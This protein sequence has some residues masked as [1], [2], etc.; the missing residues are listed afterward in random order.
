MK[1]TFIFLVL[2]FDLLSAS[3]FGNLGRKRTSDT[4]DDLPDKKKAKYEEESASQEE[5]SPEFASPAKARLSLYRKWLILNLH[6]SDGQMATERL[7][8]IY[9]QPEAIERG[10]FLPR[11][12]ATLEKIRPGTGCEFMLS[13][14]GIQCEQL[15]RTD[16]EV[17]FQVIANDLNE[18]NDTSMNL[19]HRVLLFMHHFILHTGSWWNG[20]VIE[21]PHARRDLNA[22]AEYLNVAADYYN[23][24]KIKNLDKAIAFT[25][26]YF[27]HNPTIAELIKRHKLLVKTNQALFLMG[28]KNQ[29]AD[30]SLR[31]DGGAIAAFVKS[32]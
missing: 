9:E 6:T 13:R 29:S 19:F 25:L 28:Y 16:Q 30:D 1:A 31:L 27:S 20:Q 22:A 8:R 18:N 15:S 24:Y 12:Y 10:I 21:A 2:F 14:F 17:V 7:I 11:I 5:M 4:H 32:L 23:C 3:L 26:G